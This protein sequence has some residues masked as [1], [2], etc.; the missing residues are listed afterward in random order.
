MGGKTY[1]F[2]LGTLQRHGGGG[3]AFA[4]G[5]LADYTGPAWLDGTKSRPEYVLNAA[6][7]KGF[8]QLVDVLSGLKRGDY[9]NTN[10]TATYGDINIS[11]N[12]DRL[13]NDYDTKKLVKEIK[14]E[15]FNDA[16]YRNFNNV[17]RIR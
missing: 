6:Q 5:G 2:S 15:L 8:L 3:H 10:N 16:K 4:T 11:I 9:S 12:A 1:Y 17:N 7:T 14:Q 13:A